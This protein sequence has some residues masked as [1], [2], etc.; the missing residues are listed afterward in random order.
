[1]TPETQP[2]DVPFD[3]FSEGDL[4]QEEAPKRRRGRPK[5]WRAKTIQEANETPDLAYVIWREQPDLNGK[6]WLVVLEA[7]VDPTRALE[8][9]ELNRGANVE[10]VELV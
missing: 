3:P 2:D 4:L 8:L 5:G 10:I 1:M 9:L 6:P 7:T